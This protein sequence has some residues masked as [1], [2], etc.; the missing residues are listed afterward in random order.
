M[1]SNNLYFITKLLM[2]SNKRMMESELAMMNSS[3][4]SFFYTDAPCEMIAF[5]LR[6]NE[7]KMRIKLLGITLSKC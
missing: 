7:S 2:S 6:V 4:P 5:I 1:L 3:Y